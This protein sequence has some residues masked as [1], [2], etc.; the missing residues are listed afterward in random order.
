MITAYIDKALARAHYETLEDGSYCATVPG[1]R[2]VIA[3]GDGV[4]ECRRSLAEVVEEWILVRVSRGLAIPKLG[5][6]T[7]KVR[8]AG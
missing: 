6:V 3:L 1:L 2:G 7:I 8:R 5:G 4:E